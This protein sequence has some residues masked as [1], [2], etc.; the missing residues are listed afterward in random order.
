MY[1]YIIYIGI[2]IY[3]SPRSPY[4]FYDSIVFYSFVQI[5]Y[6]LA[7]AVLCGCCRY[8][9]CMNLCRVYFQLILKHIQ[10]I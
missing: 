8:L 1:V 9:V 4:L 3:I 6:L 5:L 7:I 2:Y 10:Y